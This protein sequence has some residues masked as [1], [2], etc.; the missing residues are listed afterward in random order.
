[1][2]FFSRVGLTDDGRPPAVAPARLDTGVKLELL[3][4]FEAA[5]LGC[6]W[7]TDEHGRI[8]YLSEP[9]IRNVGLD[10]ET[11]YGAPL[12]DVFSSAGSGA[13]D[14]PERPL[15]FL[16]SA[17]NTITGLAVRVV[18][19]K[20]ETWWEFNGKPCKD[21]KGRFSGY[22]G[23]AKDITLARERQLQAEAMARSDSLTGLANRHHMEG[24]LARTL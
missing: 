15:G 7:A 4:S 22:R 14:G 6:F 3:D 2:G 12:V 21:A 10:R 20:H 17:R 23:S 13:D 24:L 8:T 16:L 9:A 18:G 5:G 11:L 1:L 19:A